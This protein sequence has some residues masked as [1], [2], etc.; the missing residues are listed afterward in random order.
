MAG[1]SMGNAGV[2]KVMKERLNTNNPY[3]NGQQ[4]HWSNQWG[5]QVSGPALAA[6]PCIALM[7]SSFCGA[8]V[9]RS[10][11]PISQATPPGC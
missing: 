3:G 6:G 11:A 7:S 10:K 4:H 1:A 5:E 2:N 9:P 8:C